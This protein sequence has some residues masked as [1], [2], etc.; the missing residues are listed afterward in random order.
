MGGGGLC[1]ALHTL[2]GEPGRKKGRIHARRYT[3]FISTG[4]YPTSADR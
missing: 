2:M 3:S 4:T 1:G